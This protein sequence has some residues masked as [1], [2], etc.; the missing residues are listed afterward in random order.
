MYTY[1]K[2]WIVETVVC[3]PQSFASTRQQFPSFNKT[4]GKSYR[5]LSTMLPTMD[6]PLAP[7]QLRKT[8]K[9]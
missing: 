5:G 2:I 1:K 4:K 6:F 9:P 3:V 8:V 7:N